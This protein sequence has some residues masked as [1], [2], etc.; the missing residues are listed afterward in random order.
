[1]IKVIDIGYQFVNMGGIDINRPHGSGDYLFLFFRTPLE[2]WID[3]KYQAVSENT[4]FLYKKGEPQ[5]YRK[6][7]GHYIND[8][9][10]V[11]IEP[12]DDYF[13]KLGIPFNT[14]IKMRESK[15]ISEMIS[16]IFIEFFDVGVQHEK[17]MEQKAN[18]MFHKFS[19]VYHFMQSNGS[20]M[21][22]YRAKLLDIRK[23]IQNYEYQPKGAEEI[24]D[25]LN[26][27]VPYFQH[28]YKEFFGNSLLQDIIYGRIEHAAHL[29]NSSVYSVTE[30][31]SLCH[32]ENLEH[33]SRQFKKVKGC[34]PSKYKKNNGIVIKNKK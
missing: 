3:G 30:V 23:K 5:R 10:H 18:A 13:E 28:L 4:Y 11:A 29:L 34:S 27:S 33:F 15:A 20:K 1:M 31:A 2:V 14:P 8:W 12:Y 32:Y 24:A 9:I 25:A 6:L 19:D 7:N 21:M 22:D 26:I 17:I 16:D